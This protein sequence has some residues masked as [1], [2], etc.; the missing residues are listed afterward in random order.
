MNVRNYRRV[1]NLKF[2]PAICAI[3]I[4]V[5]GRGLVVDYLCGKF[6]DCSSRLFDFIV[7]IDRI[8]HTHTHTHTD[9]A[10][11]LT[12]ATVIW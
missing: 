9:A 10:K 12:P 2:A 8:T 7:R 4:L 6:G 5:N 3:L 11:R 1:T